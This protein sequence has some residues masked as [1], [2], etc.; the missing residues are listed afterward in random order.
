MCVGVIISAVN[1]VLWHSVAGLPSSLG[2]TPIERKLM[3]GLSSRHSVMQI[4]D[5]MTTHHHVTSWWYQSAVV[6]GHQEALIVVVMNISGTVLELKLSP[7]IV[8]LIPFYITFLSPMLLSINGLL[9][10]NI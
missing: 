7:K 5:D 6:S 3:I 1:D 4:G 10:L 9:I 8:T 2:S